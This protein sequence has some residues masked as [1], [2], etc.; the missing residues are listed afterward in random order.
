MESTEHPGEGGYVPAEEATQVMKMPADTRLA[1][2]LLV[3]FSCEVNS[4]LILLHINFYRDTMIIVSSQ[5]HKTIWKTFIR[6]HW[7][8]GCL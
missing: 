6:G 7:R 4:T 3:S 1:H 5:R 8:A 2:V